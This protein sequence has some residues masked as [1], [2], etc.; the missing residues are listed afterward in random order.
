MSASISNAANLAA[1]LLSD[2]AD[3]RLSSLTPK[4]GASGASGREARTIVTITI[5]SS[6]Q[7][8]T[9]ASSAGQPTLSAES[10]AK[11]ATSF[12]SREGYSTSALAAAVMNPGAE[13]NS[14]GKTQAQ[15]A[16]DA[17]AVMDAK[18]ASMAAEG[19]PFDSNRDGSDHYA[20]L[21]EFDRR[22]LNAIVTDTGG[23]FSLSE[24]AIAHEVMDQQYKLGIG[25]HSGPA[26][27]N[28]QKWDVFKDDFEA[29]WAFANH[30]LDQ[31]SAEEKTSAI[32][33]FDKA[34]AEVGLE[35]SAPAG[36]AVVIS[37][38][39]SDAPD[40]GAISENPL[41]KLIK[42]AMYEPRERTR[43]TAIRN[44]EDL[45]AQEWM[46]NSRDQVDDAF[47]EAVE[48]YRIKPS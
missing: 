42:A 1:R 25:L 19:K 15:A 39:A 33:A 29:R 37:V 46:A 32:W 18:Y 41:V 21:G 8:G 5:S 40:L 14:A 4:A 28:P 12:P 44:L 24:Q 13:T 7:K 43:S 48:M 6:A 2:A 17:R 35:Q 10:I 16:L 20:L 3:A 31:V 27:E 47:R 38:G 22:T 34:Y 30:W 26:V 11:Y 36:V 45:K 23:Q 9:A